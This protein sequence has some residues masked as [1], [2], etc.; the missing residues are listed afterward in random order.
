MKIH[1]DCG[2][3]ISDST[4]NIKYKGRMIPDKNWDDFWDSIDFAIEKSGP[5]EKEKETACMQL[6]KQNIFRTMWECTNCGKL[7]IDDQNYKL[8]T[9]S[10][11]SKKY[12]EIL[13][14]A[15]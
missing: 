12:N 2:N 15:N 3:I 6:R 10:P 11:D 13:D 7:F 14:K 8:K 1:C 5:S 4:D 9:Y